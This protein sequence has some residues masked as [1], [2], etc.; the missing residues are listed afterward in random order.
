VCNDHGKKGKRAGFR[1]DDHAC[2]YNC[3][4]CG[5]SAIYDPSQGKKP[6]KTMIQV[7]EAF[8]IPESEWKKTVLDSL[9]NNYENATSTFHQ[10]EPPTIPLQPFFYPLTD[11]AEDDWCQYSI[12][13]LSS[14]GIDWK[15]YPFYCVKKTDHP[16]NKRWYGRL[17]IPT[18]K[19]NNLIFYQGRDLTDMHQKKYLSAT[20]NRDTVLHGYD[21][22]QLQ[23]SAPLYI[24]EGFFDAVLLNGVAIFG[25]KMTPQQIYWLNKSNRTKVVIPDRGEEGS[26]LAEQA[27]DLEWK[28]SLLDGN[29]DCKDVNES[30]IKNG[31]L[32]T[33]KTIVNNTTEGDITMAL[34]N[35]Y[36]K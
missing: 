33:I 31:L 16:D 32:Y 18:Y 19:D 7:L 26:L 28:V 3:F 21:K 12:E 5:I 20:T 10:M 36:C 30:I 8:G 22:L 4:N 15:T 29:D 24:T 17:I 11:D 23:T 9:L 25:N 35:M 14:R 1:F 6:S 27:I 34:T 2:G 13:Y